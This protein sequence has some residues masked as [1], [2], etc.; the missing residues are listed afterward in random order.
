MP[1]FFAAHQTGGR[2]SKTDTI[3]VCLG[4]LRI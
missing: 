1:K 3:V 4:K 2:K